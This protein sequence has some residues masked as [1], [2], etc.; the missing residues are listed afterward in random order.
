MIRFSISRRL[1]FG[2]RAKVPRDKYL[3]HHRVVEDQKV[4]KQEI[5]QIVNIS[6]GGLTMGARLLYIAHK[7]DGI[8]VVTV[9]VGLRIEVS[10]L[11]VKV[12]RDS[13][14]ERA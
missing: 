9:I 12:I 3:D 5:C 14:R 6:F 10:A 8:P 1:P 7:T 2:C 13:T 11:E 4:F